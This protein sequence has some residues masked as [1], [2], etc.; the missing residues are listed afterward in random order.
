M[1]LLRFSRWSVGLVAVTLVLASGGCGGGKKAPEPKATG[2]TAKA[3]GGGAAES[4]KA[5][6]AEGK[7]AV[8]SA[9]GDVQAGKKVFEA[10]CVACHTI[11]G[12]G[13]IGP[14]LAGVTKRREHAWLVKWL[15]D[16]PAMQ[17]SDPIAKKLLAEWKNVPMPNPMLNDKQIT[18]VLAFLEHAEKTGLKLGAGS[19]KPEK[20]EL[21]KADFE[22]AK[23]IF[24][25]RCAGC[26]GTLRKGA[27]GPN[28]EPKRTRQL[29]T[30][31]I[32]AVLTNGLPGGMPAWGKMGILKPDE[33]DLMAKFVQLPPPEPPQLPMDKIQASWHLIVPPDKR[34]TKPQTKRNW[35]NFFGVV[36]RDAGKVAIIDGDTKEKLAVINTGFAVHILR[37]SSTGRYFFAVGRDGRVSLIDLWSDPPKLVAQAQGC[38]DARSV[39]ASKYKGYEDK[40]IIEGCYWPP[41]YVVYDGTTLKPLAMHPVTSDTYDTH[42]PLKEVRVA[43]IVASHYDPLWVVSL[44]EAGY[45]GL[46]DY[47][48]PGFPMT[49][50]IPGERFLHD[51]GWDHTKRYF[52]VAANMRNQMVVVDVKNKKFITKFETG[53]K[54]HPGRGANWK[55]PKYGWVNATSH[56]GEPKLTIY[57]ADPEGSPQN[58]WKV[59][60]SIKL[61][62]AGSLFVKTHPKSPWVWIDFPLS[63]KPEITRQVCVYSKAKGAIEKCWKVADH[64]RVVHF[65][66]NAAGDEVWMSVW[67]KK[68]EIVIYDDKTLKEKKRIRGDWLVTPTGKFN[69]TNTADDVY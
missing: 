31:T 43:S 68:G 35:K 27:T 18:D 52:M 65:E 30:D 2:R 56:I 40:Y 53:I 44:K 63:N 69:V 24:F 4:G 57:G 23:K 50:K 67:D 5:A 34:P 41:Q 55:D 15:K 36:L 38:F 29:G 66:Y 1:R 20:V 9:K 49:T 17:K 32:K 21:S 37:S 11:G 39:D 59:V 19:G 6:K 58:A 28:L 25:N 62:S 7:Q 60:R 61:Q 16:P 51:G 22:R 46:V 13:R 3:E 42:E 54:P 48:K 64:G 26:H 8:A 45:V 12:K 47:S 14:D 10:M 33:V